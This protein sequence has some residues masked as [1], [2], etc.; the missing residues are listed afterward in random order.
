[1]AALS[2]YL[3]PLLCLDG[4]VAVL[5]AGLVVLQHSLLD[6]FSLVKILVENY[7]NLL[8]STALWHSQRPSLEEVKIQ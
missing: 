7:G 2:G 1:M 5:L 6:I 3:D 4:E 8:E